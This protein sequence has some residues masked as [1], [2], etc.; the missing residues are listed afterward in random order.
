MTGRAWLA[1]GEGTN[2]SMPAS[3]EEYVSLRPG[4]KGLCTSGTVAGL[5]C[6]NI[7]HARCNWDRNWGVAVG[8]DVKAG[9]EAWG[10]DAA[11]GIAIEFHGRSASY[12]LNAHRKGDPQ[13]E[14]YCIE[15]YKSGQ[16]V[17]PSMFKT[18]C[19]EDAGNTL[20]D[21]KGV[22]LFNLEFPSG[23]EY[24]ALHYCVSG[25]RLDR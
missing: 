18:R 15:H 19:W 5:Y 12:R 17:T 20:P 6:V 8:F 23:M 10:E 25:I 2:L 14:T 11:R 21:F 22:D 13:Q 9:S 3:R 24:V 4:D 7:P 1:R 16:M